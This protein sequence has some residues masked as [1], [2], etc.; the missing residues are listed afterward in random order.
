MRSDVPLSQVGRD[1]TERVWGSVID[2]KKQG[3]ESIVVEPAVPCSS[4]RATRRTHST[5]AFGLLTL[6]LI[7]P[8]HCI[9]TYNIQYKGAR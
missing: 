4:W 2:Y 3:D 9:H 7:I 8:G 5:C 6:G 1:V